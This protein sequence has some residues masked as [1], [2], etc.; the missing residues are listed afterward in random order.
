MK[1]AL[2][3]CT[4]LLGSALF[5]QQDMG[6][7]TGVVTDASGAAVPGARVTVTNRD[8][9]ET[10]FAETAESGAYTVG[11]LRI[12]RYDV[13]V[14]KQGFKKSVFSDITLHA[15]DRARA[16]LKLEVGQIVESVSVTAE[17]P[18]L[19]AETSTLSKVVAQ[20]EI[21][22]LPLNGRNFQQLAWL[23]SG[24]VPA[25]ASRDRDSGFNAHGQQ[26]TQN[27]FL[28]DGVDNN[29]N[30]MGMQDRK[31]QVVVPSL[32]A[33]AEFK[34]QTSNYSAEF[35]RNSG[36]VMIVSIKS[37]TNQFH[38]TAYE[39][40][41]NDV[42]DARDAFNYVDRNGDGKADPEPLRQNQF[43][44]TFG[45]PVRRDK[46]FFFVSWEARREHH[47]QT[48]QVTVPTPDERNGILARSLAV[49]ND[50][51][52]KQP[53]A[54]NQVPRAR[55]D[56]V[57][58]K[59]LELW[60]QP[61]FPGSGTRDNFIRNPPW[62][63][64][65]DAFDTR[66]DHDLSGKDKIFG[67]LSIS[68]SK[69]R[70][71]SV[72][73]EPARGG[74]NNDRALD[75]NSAYSIAFAYTRI[76][77]P[78]LLNEFRFGFLRQKVDKRELTDQ[79][80]SELAA[81]YGIRGIPPNGRLFGLPQFTL[82][83][84]VGY[85]GLGE[86]GSMPNFKIHQV[87]QYL[88]N[89]SWNRGNHNLKFGTDLRW[90][91]SDIFGGASSHGNL[92]FDGSFTG[93]SLADFLLGLTS[94]AA[95]AT[96]LVGQMRFRNYMFYA[97]DDW[98]V[99]PRLTLNLGLR[100]E[101]TSPWWDKHNNMN[102]L[103]L[104]PGSSFNTITTA[105]YCGD[106][107]SCRGLINTD[108]NNWAPRFGLA[109]QVQTRTVLRAGFGVFYG[110]QGSLGADGRG[111]NNF[112]YNRS[113]TANS[114][115]S[116][117][118]LQLSSGYPDN[119]LGSPNAPP[120]QNLNWIVW[121]QDFPSPQVAQWN[122]AVQRELSRSLS[123]TVAYVGSGTSYI[124]DAYNWNGADP[125]PPAT[126]KNRRRIPA[127][128]NI[129][130]RSPI[131]HSTYHGMDAQLERRFSSGLSFSASYTWSH[132]LDNVQE[133][134][135]SG[136]GNFQSTKDLSSAK[137]NTNFDMRHRFV[138][139][140]VYELPVGRGRRWMKRGGLLDVVLGGWQLSGMAAVQT[141]HYFDITVPNAR[142]VLGASAIGDWWPDRI[143]NPRL[144]TRTADRWF[145]TAA[146]VMPRNADGSYRFGNAGRGVLD[147]DGLFNLDLGLMKNFRLTERFR[148][149]FRWE[150]FNV[151]NTPTLSDPT[152]SLGN[153]DF[154][155]SRGTV[156]TPRQMQFA[157]RLSF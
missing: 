92:T 60:P 34:V 61:N 102:R 77:R 32:D 16:D 22:G 74:Q 6:V 127:W 104:A 109:Y 66:I 40:V 152:A 35:G 87:Y 75:D 8:T 31:M 5:A 155:K 157:L 65:R 141:G 130:L 53:F 94:Q 129:N 135:G 69:T 103:E 118:A 45:G 156:S 63:V 24:A 78:T 70:R 143:A 84:R 98:K 110:G 29:N 11:P 100:Y 106:S 17:A 153:P 148:L 52:T 68:P 30:V 93:I 144:E 7:I 95:L 136:G 89:V 90:N 37:G 23:S 12:G 20:D 72:F 125:G 86:P 126:E 115:G 137:G 105:G 62:T 55:F 154:G 2:L 58:A 80:L 76:F 27:S 54:N 121:Q 97:L 128:N 33:V 14:E 10:R 101:L 82:S 145:D 138:S 113:V 111:I 134:F 49:I 67:R 15:Q 114:A 26:M 50:P 120:P 59:V 117:P 28:I 99:T 140:A 124:M 47:S 132:A 25:T 150:S 71:E 56:P 39:Y 133:Q 18:L 42:F 142:T 91:R 13:A 139:G 131:G 19:Q 46:T 116:N 41:R 107:W 73:P 38:G 57:A 44:G 79:P 64:D 9:N 21:R 48:D 119:F 96:Q 151:S 88:D 1:K 36:A 146:F 83:G 81:Q 123:L 122:V 149:Q 85:Q 4:A 43:G 108:T 3:I 147:G 51:L 112:P